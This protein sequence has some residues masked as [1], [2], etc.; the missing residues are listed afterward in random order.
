MYVYI[1]I[2]LAVLVDFFK[3]DLTTPAL[4]VSCIDLKSQTQPVKQKHLKNAKAK[5]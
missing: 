4:R 2:I 3:S 1:Y 5:S